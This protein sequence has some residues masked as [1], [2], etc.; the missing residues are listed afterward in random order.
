MFAFQ[1]QEE[2]LEMATCLNNGVRPELEDEDTYFV[3]DGFDSVPEI[4]TA[5]DFWSTDK[6]MNARNMGIRLHISR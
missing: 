3:V 2:T 4:V 5:T 6:Y 1:L